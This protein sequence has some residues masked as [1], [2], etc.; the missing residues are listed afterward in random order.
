MRGRASD[1]A[2]DRASDSIE[3]TMRSRSNGFGCCE[4]RIGTR[5]GVSDGDG[6]PYNGLRYWAPTICCI[7]GSCAASSGAINDY[8]GL[9][10]ASISYD[11]YGHVLGLF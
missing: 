4:A 10:I 5:M 1:R 7:E 8:M 2:G 11:D 3:L 6:V 9:R